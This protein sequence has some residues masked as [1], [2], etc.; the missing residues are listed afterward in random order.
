MNKKDILYISLITVFSI[1][2][3]FLPI[4]INIFV[5]IGIIVL[6]YLIYSLKY[7][8]EYLEYEEMVNNF[9]LFLRDLS[10]YLKIGQP[11]PVALKSVSN[12]YYGK[13]LNR[14]IKY[15]I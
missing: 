14:E 4:N 13:R 2:F 1:F 9:P 10:H 5:K 6:L 8:Q 3:I 12:N 15:I 7:L 11:L